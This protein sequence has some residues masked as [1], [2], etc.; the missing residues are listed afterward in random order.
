MSR[1][2]IAFLFVAAMGCSQDEGTMA[3]SAAAC[4]LAITPDRMPTLNKS[5][6]KRIDFGAIG[7]GAGPDSKLPIYRRQRQ[8]GAPLLADGNIIK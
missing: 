8:L 5:C 2:F 7:T 4:D 3:L 1:L 6:G